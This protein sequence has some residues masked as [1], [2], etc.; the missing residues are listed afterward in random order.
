MSFIQQLQDILG[1]S[2]KVNT[3]DA[4]FA[5]RLQSPST[6][7]TYKISLLLAKNLGNPSA[8]LSSWLT[9]AGV[10]DQSDPDRF[11]FLCS[12]TFIPGTNMTPFETFGDVQGMYESFSGPRRDM[13]MAFTFYVGSDYQTL[14]LFEE[15]VNYMNPIYAPNQLTSASPGGYESHLNQSVMYRFRYPSTYKRDIAI[16]KFERDYRDNI[17]YAF[18][19]AFPTNIESI[20]LTYDAGQLLKVTVSMRYDRK[21]IIQSRKQTVNNQRATNSFPSL[22]A[23]DSKPGGVNIDAGTLVG[24]FQ[25][26]PDTLT[27]NWLVNGQ[28]LTSD[29]TFGSTIVTGF[30]G[31]EVGDLT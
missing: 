31:A 14:R 11:D 5:S 8:D 1:S 18:K 19:S 4:T 28:L 23:G 21:V 13:E 30:D 3:N 9:S 7:N 26:G 25:S 15:W 16:T 12:E 22:F 29:T 10:F 6:T 17:T 20:P 2:A 27:Q 24:E